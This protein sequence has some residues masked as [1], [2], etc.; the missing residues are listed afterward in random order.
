M[1][2][3]TQ[4]LITILD[5]ELKANWQGKRVVLSSESRIN[6]PVVTKLLNMNRVNKVFAYQDFRSQIHQYQLEHQVSGIIWRSCNFCER[7]IKY[8]EIHNQLIP[9]KADKQ[10]LIAAKQS[11]IEFWQQ[12]TATMQFWLAQAPGKDHPPV[13]ETSLKTS[14][15]ASPSTPHQPIGSEY[16][17]KLIRQAEWA[18]VDATRNEVYLGLCWGDPEEYR[19]QWAKPKSGCDRIIASQTV[20]SSIKI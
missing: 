3:T 7:K 5:R 4:D 9:L 15:Q 10:T 14:S 20:P 6:D 11:V 18:E 16:V 12:A 17:Q 8:P 13:S 1:T 2:Y 19:Y